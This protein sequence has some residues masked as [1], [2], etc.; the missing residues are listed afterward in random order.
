MAGFETPIT[1]DDPRILYGAANVSYD[2]AP[3]LSGSVYGVST[4]V[5]A[6]TF[7]PNLNG[8][9]SG[10]TLP[11]SALTGVMGYAGVVAGSSTTSGSTTGAPQFTANIFGSTTSAGSAAGY[12]GDSGF[13]LGL[14]LS[15][16]SVTGT[17]YIP[18]PADQDQVAGGL[19]LIFTPERSGAPY[20]TFTATLS[21][22][23]IVTGGVAGM[24]RIREEDDLEIFTLLGIL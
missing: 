12:E 17:S 6:V 3:L 2:G 19:P 14:T 23:S 1:Y 16:G 10:S 8:S 15:A 7:S 9:A 18:E 24:K 21:G 22:I 5:N 4:S 13:I 20:L 11:T